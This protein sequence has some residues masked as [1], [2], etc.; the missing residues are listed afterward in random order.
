[1]ARGGAGRSGR[2]DPIVEQIK[3]AELTRVAGGPLGA[4][5]RPVGRVR[6]DV[7]QHRRLHM[8][9]PTILCTAI[10]LMQYAYMPFHTTVRRSTAQWMVYLYRQ[11]LSVINGQF[12]R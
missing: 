4:H 1:M 7:L 3:G 6:D 2:E 12:C 8:I 10:Y 11:K 5:P 9:F